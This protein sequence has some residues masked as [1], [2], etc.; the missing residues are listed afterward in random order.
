MKI[1]KSQFKT[2]LQKLSDEKNFKYN[3][4][5]K[6]SIWREFLTNKERAGGKWDKQ[7]GQQ[8]WLPL[9]KPFLA[10]SNNTEE[11]YIEIKD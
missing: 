2:A 8:I 7:T 1:F 4:W 3:E 6:E 5:D 10:E 9:I 11:E